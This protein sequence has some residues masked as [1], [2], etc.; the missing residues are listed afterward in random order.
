MKLRCVRES[1]GDKK[2]APRGPVHRTRV[3]DVLILIHPLGDARWDFRNAVEHE[4]P[5][6][7]GCSV[8]NARIAGD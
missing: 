2:T 5:H 8:R 1:G 6:L 3:S 4:R 7:P